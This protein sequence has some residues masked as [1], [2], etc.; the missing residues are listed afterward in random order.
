MSILYTAQGTLESLESL[1]LLDL[2]ESYIDVAVDRS[3][4]LAGCPQ[5]KPCNSSSD[6]QN[7]LYCINNACSRTGAQSVSNQN[8]V[9]P[10]WMGASGSVD[11][12]APE[13]GAPKQYI[14][15]Y[16]QNSQNTNKQQKNKPKW[17]HLW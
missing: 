17:Y 1:D 14:P 8:M 13:D 10:S 5:G 11:I 4:S 15:M 12:V 16:S 3:C 7:G 9:Y 2:L 6:C